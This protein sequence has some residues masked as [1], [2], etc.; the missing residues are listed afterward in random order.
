MPYS[1][2]KCSEKEEILNTKNRIVH[3]M[4][5]S[6]MNIKEFRGIKKCNK[7]IKLSKFTVLIG[8]NNSGK[9]SILEALSLL[10]LPMGTAKPYYRSAMNVLGELHHDISSMIY[11]YSG[12]AILAYKIGCLVSASV[13]IPLTVIFSCAIKA[14]E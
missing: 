9:S 12:K 10:P 3:K 8:K 7:P 1:V 2:S 13:I 11:G 6:E 5:V 4:F 14:K